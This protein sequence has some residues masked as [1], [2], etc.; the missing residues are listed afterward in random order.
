ML[1][2]GIISIYKKY[3]FW[4]F[5]RIWFDYVRQVEN[6]GLAYASVIPCNTQ[7]IKKHI[8]ACDIIIFPWGEDIHPN[9]YGQEIEGS[10][11]LHKNND[12]FLLECLDI[13]INMKKPIFGI[14]KGMQLINIYFWGSLIQN[15]AHAELHNNLEKQNS[16]VHSIQL[17]W[18]SVLWDIFPEKKCDVNSIH[19]QA[20]DQLW[21][22]LEVIAK[23]E[24]AY[25]EAIK[26]SHKKIIGVQWHPEMMSDNTK[27]FRIILEHLSS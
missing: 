4:E 15:I 16:S 19:H 8:E 1:R 3:D 10:K 14:C 12:T 2:V 25:I 6:T 7:Y 27:F 18:D 11:S 23:S 20:I 17:E 9:L 5:S 26:H 24:D 13:A 21:E 22:G